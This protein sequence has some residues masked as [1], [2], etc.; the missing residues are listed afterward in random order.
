MPPIWPPG[1]GDLIW[2]DSAPTMGREQSKR[3]MTE[4]SGLAIVCP[5]TSRIR[6]YPTGVVLPRFQVRSV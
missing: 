5:I 2:T 6:H 3:L 4:R 1:A